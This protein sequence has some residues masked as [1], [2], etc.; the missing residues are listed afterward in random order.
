M[1]PDQIETLVRKV[2]S[3]LAGTVPHI[4]LRRLPAKAWRYAIRRALHNFAV[5][6][7][8]DVA[9]TLTYSAVLSIFPALLALLTLLSLV[10]EQQATSRW[11]IEFASQ[12]LTSDIVD[13]LREPITRLT[14]AQ[15]AGWVLALSLLLALWGANLYVSAFGRAMN[16][17]YGVAEG[18]PFWKVIPY[19]LMLT[20]STLLFGGLGLLAMVLS[21]KLILILNG[22]TPVPRP[23]TGGTA[24]P[25]PSPSAMPSPGASGVRPGA[26]LQQ[27]DAA[28]WPVLV[29][30]AIVYTAALYHLTPN[31]RQGR[32]RWCTPGSV[33]AILGMIVAVLGFNAYVDQFST[34]NETYGIVGS[35]ICLLLGLWL[36]N[37]ALLFGGEVD[38]ELDRTC[39]LL[40]G[41]E[42]E[43]TI[44]LP[45]RDIA[46]IQRVVAAQE[47][48]VAEG[49]AMRRDA[50]AE[51]LRLA[52]QANHASE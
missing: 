32:F 48:L 30:G 17:V 37:C 12:H 36:I 22:F 27:W 7:D 31:V 3:P 49:R 4:P 9:G 25:L 34:F 44:Q 15:H 29:L 6:L 40:A 10:G 50:E 19:N 46:A 47:R 42:A 26:L 20:A 39:Q 14:Q 51:R 28:R 13:L 8:I 24:S 35:F 23:H 38:A 18:R 41:V 1:E 43:R 52:E 11:L 2:T 5:N 21:N 16:R 33:V 45:P